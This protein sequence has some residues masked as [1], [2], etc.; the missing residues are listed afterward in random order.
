MDMF[1]V[2]GSTVHRKPPHRVPEPEGGFRARMCS[3]FRLIK[4][5]WSVIG[6]VGI[7]C[8]RIDAA[9]SCELLQERGCGLM[10]VYTYVM[11]LLNNC[12]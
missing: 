3:R 9:G 11:S 10:W 6:L 7:R 1:M 4:L 12:Q 5:T 2:Q 8:M